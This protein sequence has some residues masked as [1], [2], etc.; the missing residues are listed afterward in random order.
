MNNI[1]STFQSGTFD[2]S[3]TTY[4]YQVC[5]DDFSDV[6][7]FCQRFDFSKV[8]TSR[9]VKVRPTNDDLFYRG[10]EFTDITDPTQTFVLTGEIKGD[11]KFEIAIPL[12]INNCPVIERVSI[13]TCEVWYQA[14]CKM[15]RFDKN[16]I[17]QVKVLAQV[18]EICGIDITK[19]LNTFIIDGLYPSN[20]RIES[21][22]YQLRSAVIDK[23]ALYTKTFT[24]ATVNGIFNQALR[25]LDVV[26]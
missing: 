22:K 2:R 4:V 16:Y 12:K 23:I 17:T 14:I 21:A 9:K 6:R 8:D 26:R 19:D 18:A 24:P 25:Q 11:Y 3:D 15:F 1:S 5:G 10:Y 7:D 13:S 20:P